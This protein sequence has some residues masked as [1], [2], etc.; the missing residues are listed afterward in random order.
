MRYNHQQEAGYM[1]DISRFVASASL[2][3][4]PQKMPQNQIVIIIQAIYNLTILKCH[5]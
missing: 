3:T 1:F 5:P 2:F 4:P